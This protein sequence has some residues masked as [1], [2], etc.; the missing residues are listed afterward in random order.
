MDVADKET[1]SFAKDIEKFKKQLEQDVAKAKRTAARIALKK[2]YEKSPA[3]T[4]NYMRS[5]KV[6]I[7]KT[8]TGRG[9]GKGA[10]VK[11]YGP[12]GRVYWTPRMT[13][14][15][16]AALT[17]ELY[18]KRSAYISRFQLHDDITIYNNIFYAH[19]VEYFGWDD[20][21]GPNQKLPPPRPYFVY[22]MTIAE[23]TV[24]MPMLPKLMVQGS[25]YTAI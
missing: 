14:G 15:E 20:L 24:L 8:K 12:L 5:H 2:L 1:M 9:I 25:F 17:K 16:K 6:G 23:L 21:A 10:A 4:G 22:T 18:A 11:P 3:R 19:R 13:P 7:A